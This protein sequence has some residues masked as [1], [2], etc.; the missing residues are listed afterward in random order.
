MAQSDLPTPQ[1]QAQALGA[2]LDALCSRLGISK[3]K[4]GNPL[5]SVLEAVSETET[6]STYDV[7]KALKA[8]D[9]D[10]TTGAALQAI[11]A[12]EKLPQLGPQYARTNVNFTDTNFVKIASNITHAGAAPVA[13]SLTI[14]V[15]KTPTFDAAPP[16]GTIYIGRGTPQSEGPL[17]YTGKADSGSYWSLT[18]S[19]PTSVF[20]NL[21]EEVVV[22]QGGDRPINAG[23]AVFTAPGV[24]SAPIQFTVVTGGSI[25]DGE[26]E[27]LDVPVVCTSLGTIGNV[28]ENTITDFGGS[29][30]F[31]GAAVTNPARVS[32]GRDTET[33]RQYRDRI[34]AKRNTRQGG[35]DLAI[36]T[37]ARGITS[38]DES[39]TVLSATLLRRFGQP[40]LLTID[41][42][43]GYQPIWDGTPYEVLRSVSTGGEKDFKLLNTPIVLASVETINTSP[44]PI[45]NG[46]DLQVQVG[47]KAAETHVFN[48]TVFNDS[49]N[50]SSYDAVSSINANT[51]LSFYAK[52]TSNSAKFALYPK[53]ESESIQVLGG[54]ANEVLGFPVAKAYTALL[55][56]NDR[57]LTTSN[58][59][60]VLDRAAGNL[61]LATELAAGDTLSMGSLWS[62]GFVESAAIDTITLADDVT[63]WAAIDNDTT[64]IDSGKGKVSTLTVAFS[65]AT[66][67]SFQA[68]V[69]NTVNYDTDVTVG[70]SLLLYTTGTN[71]L[72][73]ALNG[74]WKI[75]AKPTSDKVTIELPQMRSARKLAAAANFPAASKKVFIC[76]GLC[77]QNGGILNTAEIYNTETGEFTQA[78]NMSYARYGH[79][80]T[81]MNTGKILVVGGLGTDG[82][83]V[84]HTELYD[85][86]TDTWYIADTYTEAAFRAA[87][88]LLDS[89][90]VLVTGGIKANGVVSAHSA[91]YTEGTDAWSMQADFDT[92]RYGHSLI[93]TD[94]NDVFMLGGLTSAT[95]NKSCTYT[96]NLFNH[97][98][99]TWSSKAAIPEASTVTPNRNVVG[100]LYAA[101]H[102]VAVIDHLYYRYTVETNTWSF[103]GELS[104]VYGW[105]SPIRL[106][107]GTSLQ[108]EESDFYY[109]GWANPVVRSA[110]G[111]LTI[112]F[113]EYTGADGYRKPVHLV[114]NTGTGYWDVTQI[115]D[116]VSGCKSMYAAVALNGSGH[117]HE[118]LALGGQATDV[119]Y[120]GGEDVISS[121]PELFNTSTKAISYNSP[122]FTTFPG[123]QGWCI[124]RH[125]SHTEKCVIPSGSNYTSQTLA[126]TISFDGAFTNT[127]QTN[128]IRVSSNDHSGDFT[129]LGPTVASIENEVVY[130]SG[131]SLFANSKSL[132]S[133]K[134]IPDFEVLTIGSLVNSVATVPATFQVA[135]FG[136]PETSTDPYQPIATPVPL[137]ATLVGLSRKNFL[138]GDAT[139]QINVAEYG[140]FKQE[141][142]HIGSWSPSG[143]LAVNYDT[144]PTTFTLG[145]DADV[146]VIPNQSVYFGLPYKFTKAENLSITV[147]DNQSSGLF[148]VPMAR[149]VK[150]V[151]TT[152]GTQ[153]AIRDSDN[154][155]LKMARAFG[156]DYDFKNFGVL[157][158]ARAKIGN[159]L[160]RFYRHGAEG[161]SY[162]VRYMYQTEPSSST[163]VATSYNYLTAQN[164]HS[165]KQRSFID[166]YLPSGAAYT[167]NAINPTS[168]LSITSV[169]GANAVM[170][171]HLLTGLKVYSVERNSV[172]GQT[173]MIVQF[174][175]EDIM[176][177]TLA[178]NVLSVNQFIH[179]DAVTSTP[180]TLQTGQTQIMAISDRDGD[181]LTLTIAAGSLDD[182]TATM[183]LT[184]NPGTIS[185]DPTAQNAVTFDSSIVAGDIVVLKNLPYAGNP[186]RVV[187]TGSTYQW[188]YCKRLGDDWDNL[189]SYMRMVNTKDNIVVYRKPT[190]TE[191]SLASDITALYNNGESPVSATLL[192]SGTA[193]VTRASW[194][195]DASPDW[196]NGAPLLDGYNAVLSTVKPASV[197]VDAEIILKKTASGSLATGT[198]WE[199]EVLYLVPEY[200]KDVVK[201]LNTPCITGLWSQAEVKTADS[202]TS[203]QISSLT[204]GSSGSIQVSGVG[205]N[206]TAA[207]VVNLL[208]NLADNH[209]HPSCVVAIRKS[210]ADYFSGDSWVKVTNTRTLPKTYLT[211][212]TVNS[213]DSNGVVTFS[214]TPYTLRGSRITTTATIEPAGDFVLVRLDNSLTLQHVVEGDFLCLDIPLPCN[215]TT[216]LLAVSDANKGTFR[217]IRRTHNNSVFWIENPNAVFEKCLLSATIVSNDSL[218]P[219]NLMT[220]ADEQ[221]GV[222]NKG[223]WEIIS[224]GASAP[225]SPMYGNNTVVLSIAKKTPQALSSATAF[226][227]SSI[228]FAEGTP[229][230]LYRKI[231]GISINSDNSNLT[232]VKLQGPDLGL[233]SSA[234]G[235]VIT[236]LNKLEFPAGVNTGTDAYKYNTG[237]IKEVSKVLYGDSSDPQTYPGVISNG[238][239]VLMD[240]PVLKRIKAAFAVRINGNPNKDLADRIKSMIAG[241]INSSPHGQNISVS[242]LTTAADTV[243]GVVSTTPINLSDQIIVNSQ[244]KAVVLNLNDIS[245]VFK[246]Q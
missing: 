190:S 105:G 217:I 7:L 208:Y 147:D 133:E 74:V 88:I 206:S 223:T 237:L 95:D 63:L 225:N 103:V 123:E 113:A 171:T 211:S 8:R 239:S 233:V 76:G 236:A 150:P 79:T 114:Y 25:P 232:E 96:C 184:L 219:G 204:P 119:Y 120:A 28:P 42:G 17:A 131:V 203:V 102:I 6:R 54:S 198:D 18:L 100:G 13:G 246:G 32:S 181:K 209:N 68:T 97:L 228:Q 138:E 224:V 53:D 215:I 212:G 202:G 62:R 127:Y 5:L 23:Q 117:T 10:N 231:L 52:V 34:K 216:S 94:T 90:S 187:E 172:G 136:V 179:Y 132:R 118:V 58:N 128:K 160:Y 229:S 69:Q 16:I 162:V 152:Y 230:V 189:D 157:M 164:I 142:A 115:P 194:D 186:M 57:H 45:Q 221:F 111:N 170:D 222:T 176:L 83:P 155:G 67:S 197:D 183:P 75:I 50:G 21:G 81:L 165:F 40:S 33:A 101:G 37:A 89:G 44:F 151:G 173:T 226:T 24:L 12:D 144:L 84:Q 141:I 47:S 38:P 213:I 122:L 135:E 159:I 156:V 242:S 30:P 112:L 154:D 87:A 201:W 78:A 207:S 137:N 196:Q 200:A 98:G 195:Y 15:D 55:Y 140:N 41:D 134:D 139:S 64:I 48:T 11:G 175:S 145:L 149:K 22:G 80:A 182:G 238:A 27:L 235:S 91:Y 65:K 56:K 39:K 214:A 82:L 234:A 166:V 36:T 66:P 19:S 46:T 174:P 192:G 92:A 43:N 218:V 177:D 3:L 220:F 205:A 158:Q 241:A 168:Q 61:T 121:T 126:S 108:G 35:T 93:L 72:P 9:V 199:N 143:A 71:N 129:L 73:A 191:T 70:D 163:R 185:F 178:T 106:Y 104:I 210:D 29:A 193:S 146:P 148:T 169:F 188:L 4:V 243:D 116:N 60:Y 153:F 125:N 26:T 14:N 167:G 227:A 86:A 49:S 2:M 107:N 244:E 77:G 124:F 1:S 109:F 161:E 99:E 20:H 245:I 180:T 85:T 31:N 110:S 59:D 51:A 130:P 240:G